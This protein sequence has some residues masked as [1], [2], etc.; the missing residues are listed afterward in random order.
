M[1]LPEAELS[2]KT[3]TRLLA[4]VVVI[5]AFSAGLLAAELQEQQRLYNKVEDMFVRVR[6]QLGRPETQRLIDESYEL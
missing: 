4:V 6:T 1:K 2:H 5:L 3:T